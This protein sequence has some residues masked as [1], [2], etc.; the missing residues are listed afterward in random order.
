MI[1]EKFKQKSYL[2]K[3][4]CRGWKEIIHRSNKKVGQISEKGCNFLLGRMCFSDDGACQNFLVT[5]YRLEYH[6]RKL[7]HT[8]LL[9]DTNVESNMLNLANGRVI[10]KFNNSAKVQ[11]FSLYSNL[12]LNWYI[13]YELYNCPCNPTNSFACLFGTV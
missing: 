6:L 13:V 2:K 1:T 3:K 10:I 12:A 4:R 11:N 7:Y 8:N 9:C 5:E